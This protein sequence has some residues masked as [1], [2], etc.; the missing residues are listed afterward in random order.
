RIRDF[1]E[2]AHQNWG[3]TFFLLGGDTDTIPCWPGQGSGIWGQ[4]PDG[5]A[6]SDTGYGDYDDDKIYEVFVGRAPVR[7]TTD[8]EVFI[9]KTLDYEQDPPRS[10]YAKTA[11]FFGFDANARLAGEDVKE[12]IETLHLPTGWTLSEEYDSEEGTHRD[13]VISYLNNGHHLVNH[14][15]HGEWWRI[16]VGSVNHYQWLRNDTHIPSLTNGTTDPND[17]DGRPRWSIIYSASCLSNR[18]WEDPCVGEAFLRNPNG[19]GVA[20]VGNT[21]QSSFTSD[22]PNGGSCRYDRYFFR[23][24]FDDS[25]AIHS[26]G[27]VFAYSKAQ[28]YEDVGGGYREYNWYH[29][30]LLGDPEL[31]IWTENPKSLLAWYRVRIP[32]LTGT[33]FVVGIQ[34][35][36]DPVGDACVCL[37]KDGEIY[38]VD[39]PDPTTGKATFNINPATPGRLDVT[40]TLHN[41]IPHQGY[42]MVQLLP[43]AA[44]VERCHSERS[45]ESSSGRGKMLRC[46][47]HDVQPFPL[48][49]VTPWAPERMRW[50]R[51]SSATVLQQAA[52]VAR[53]HPGRSGGHLGSAHGSPT[54]DRA[55]SNSRLAAR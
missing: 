19:G 52:G 45:E 34:T 6:D 20:Y 13:D 55:V 11:A 25:D 23:A 9:D 41:Y 5:Y 36:G 15:D 8:I 53:A 38:Q 50:S 43:G 17:P 54:G 46:A 1:I 44:N 2:D 40:V 39:Y 14:F 37:W 49:L 10:D 33:E 42:S 7:T 27:E 4:F 48:P 47:Q 51:R 30:T 24:I 32:A 18:L 16:G 21:G 3:V 22:D 26:L 28:A 29:P 31:P 12:A 35:Q